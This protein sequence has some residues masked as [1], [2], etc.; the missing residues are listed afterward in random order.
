LNARLDIFLSR[1]LG[2]PGQEELAFG[3]LTTGDTRVL[4]REIIEAIG[5]SNEQIDQITAKVKKEL[6]RRE[7]LYRGAR[8]PLKLEGLTVLLV[9]DG[10]ATGSSMRAAINALRKMKPAR[11][12]VAVPVAPLSTC[13]RLKREVDDLVCVYSPKDFY[14]I[15]QFYENFLQLADEEV[16]EL[17]RRAAEPRLQQVE[18]KGA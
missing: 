1:K 17:L 8:A 9:D 10:I 6:E 16:T 15:G 3:A 13:N 2:V 18:Q 11:I 7:N 5:I 4:D 14:A 12:V